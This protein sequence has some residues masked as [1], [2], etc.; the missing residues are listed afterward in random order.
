MGDSVC[1]GIV[2]MLR[3]ELCRGMS[4]CG[5]S[6][7]QEVAVHPQHVDNMRPSPRRTPPWTACRR[8]SGWTARAEPQPAATPGR[9]GD[10]L[11]ASSFDVPVLD[12][13]P[14]AV[15]TVRYALDEVARTWVAHV[16]D[17]ESGEMLREVPATDYHHQ[18]AVLA[19]LRKQPGVDTEA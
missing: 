11:D 17:A 14:S 12:G 6:Y 2:S 9:R 16:F 10:P 3:T 7:R 13:G 18:M 15:I 4:R 5:T 8:W 1:N 19:A